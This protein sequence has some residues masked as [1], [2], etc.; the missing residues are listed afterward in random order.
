MTNGNRLLWAVLS[1]WAVTSFAERPPSVAKAP[2]EFHATSA[3][4]QGPTPGAAYLATLPYEM[5]NKLRKDGR[6]LL[7][8]QRK[9]GYVHAVIR[10]ER[11]IDEAYALITQPARQQQYVPHVAQ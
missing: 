2:S 10:L 11:P 6:V 7:E 4:A 9:K 8:L 1:F 5:R 3:E